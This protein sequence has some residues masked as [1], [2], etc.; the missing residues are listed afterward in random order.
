MALASQ[1]GQDSQISLGKIVL[2]TILFQIAW[3]W[4]RIVPVLAHGELTG[5]DDF[6]RLH[7]IRN[8]MGGQSWFDLSVQRMAPPL[9]ADI[10][11]SRFVDVPIAGL[12]WFFDIF[13]SK[14]LA[15]RIATVIW[16][17]MLLA[18][19]V[20]AV[21][22]ICDR[23]LKQYNRLLPLL[24]AVS[25]VTTLVQF[26]PGRI[27]HHNVQI[28]LL[29][30]LVLGLVSRETSW[31][32]YLMGFSMA[33]SVSIG[34]DTIILFLPILAV[35]GYHW[36]IGKDAGG[37]GLMRV[38]LSLSASTIILYLLNFAPSGYL[39]FRC[40]ANSLFYASAL[41][42]VSTSFALLAFASNTLNHANPT[43]CFITRA[44]AGIA[45]AGTSTAVLLYAF[46][47]CTDGPLGALS[48]EAKTRWL[49]YV[50]EAKPL[51]EVLIEIPYEWFSTVA[52]VLVVLIAGALVLLNPKYRS[53]NLVALYTVVLATALASFLQIR[54]LRSGIYLSI[55][56]CVIFAHM[57]YHFLVRHLEGKKVLAMGLQTAIVAVLISAT[58][59]WAGKA[60]FSQGA[61][62]AHQTASAAPTP[63]KTTKVQRVNPKMCFGEPD[64]TFLSTLNTGT[65]MSDL[66]SATPILV[67]TGHSVVSG[68]Y[69]RNDEAIVDVLDFFES[70][71]ATAR[72][73]IAKYGLDYVGLCVNAMKLSVEEAKSDMMIARI[74]RDDLPR[75]LE[76]VSPAGSRF[77]VLRIRH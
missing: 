76:T 31:G 73:L 58:W 4:G 36:A 28:L 41:V 34:L 10:H 69:H 24:F 9:G 62:K 74:M 48:D 6:L 63:E 38:A 60:I 16:P 33:L 72:P 19:V 21:T 66:D 57:S 17:T 59:F 49:A 5:P 47:H 55:P 67:H 43:H 65:I 52:Y 70:P 50:I 26:A 64:Y 30:L 29:T 39:D 8:W 7:Q 32:D 75:W 44:I 71:S 14:I 77:K 54:V 12:I 56:F 46:P 37:R 22:L 53:A 2:W 3:N 45:I 23:L 18:A 40:D 68:P 61:A 20:V 25:C 13:T 51:T 35:V 11:W 42:L 15:E 27:D 1:Q